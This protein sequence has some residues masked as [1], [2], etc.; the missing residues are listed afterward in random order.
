MTATLQE[1]VIEFLEKKDYISLKHILSISLVQD[2][3]ELFNELTG[4]QVI[5]LFRML[6]KHKQSE[7]FS[8]LEQDEQETL[9]KTFS[10]KEAASILAQLSPD[11]RTALFEELP[12]TITRKLFKLLSLDDLKETR[13][14]LGYPEESVGRMMTPDYVF[15]SK[16]IRVAE[17]LHIIRK[18]GNDSETLNRVYVVDE[19]KKLLDSIKLRNIILAN[20]EQKIEELLDYNIVS[21]DAHDDREQA[22]KL[23]QKYDVMALP[24]IDSEGM[25]IGIVT[26]DDV[27]DVAEE[28][29]TEDI[30]KIASV[31]PL[32][33]SYKTAGIFTL[34]H[35]RILWLS[36]LVF[37]SLFSSGILALFEET[38]SSAIVLAFFIPLLIGS[39][40]NIGSQSATLM[41]RAIAT[42]DVKLNEWLK[43]VVKEIIM[44]LLLGATLGLLA[45]LIGY[46][47]GGYLIGVVVGLAMLA[48]ILTANLIGA[49]LPFILSRLRID[50]AIASSPLITTIVDALGLVI[51]FS[52]A[53]A[54]L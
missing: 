30:Q 8:Y 6:P 15:V 13:L 39:G 41:I 1:I 19:N 28:E 47:R 2:L 51:Y 49:V 22:V 31:T 45:S 52:I 54:I 27:L 14:L 20:E 10:N 18:Q 7:V 11:D 23:M 24:V 5:L 9:L 35:K 26:F 21:L 48:I 25:L 38:L 46:F 42:E 36:L 33:T 29:A 4:V 16:D 32:K 12:G 3:A 17:A 44:G 53:I 37:V 34:Y 40:G 50:P 43:V